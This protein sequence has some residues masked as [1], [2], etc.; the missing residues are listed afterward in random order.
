[1]S[2]AKNRCHAEETAACCCVDVGTVI[3]NQNC[4]ASFEKS[5]LNQDEAETMLVQLM[6]KARAVESEP[7]KIEHQIQP[8]AEGVKLIANFTFCCEAETLI[9]QLNLR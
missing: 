9:F 4:T 8:I 7:C 1:M 6:E 3:D 5:F 2:D